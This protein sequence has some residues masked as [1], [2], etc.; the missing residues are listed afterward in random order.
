MIYDGASS[1]M[2][3]P[4]LLEYQVYLFVAIP[5]IAATGLVYRGARCDRRRPSLISETGHQYKAVQQWPKVTIKLHIFLRRG[6]PFGEHS[7]STRSSTTT[8]RVQ[9][10]YDLVQ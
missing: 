6:Q 1:T 7:S 2:P 5:G 8:I 9:L 10:L 3:K 4:A